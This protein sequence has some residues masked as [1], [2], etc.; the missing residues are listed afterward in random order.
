MTG[1]S[2]TAPGRL[3]PPAGAPRTAMILVALATAGLVVSVQQ[4]LV[5]PLLPRLME[6]F[7]VSVTAVTW[8]FTASL[9]AGAVATPLLSRFGDMYGKKRMI[10]LAIGTLAAGSVVC[11]LSG[12]LGV[13]IAGRAL[14][15]VSVALIP[16]AIGTI[17][18]AFPAHRV[19][20]AIGVISAT[21]GVGGTIGMIV[22]GL[23]ADR[24]T[25]HAPVFLVAAGLALVGMALIAVCA[26]DVGERPGGRP[27]YAGAVLLAAWLICMLLAISQGNAWGWTSPGVLGLFVAAAVLCAVWVVLET[28]IREPLVRLSLLVGS[29]SLSANLASALLGFSMYAMFTLIAGFIQAPRDE[30][31]YGLSGSVLDVGLYTLPST[32]TMLGCSVLA[33]RLA[34]RIGPAFTLAV[35]SVFAG[36]SWMW[37]AFSNAHVY[38]MLAFNAIQGVGFGIAYAALGTLA[39]EHVPMHQSGIA[40]GINALVRTTGGSISGAA[41]A[42]V[43]T[44]YTVAGTDTP[45]LA[46][47]ELC[48]WITAA[49]AALAAVVA[50]VHG[51][52]HRAPAA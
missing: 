35:G 39:V 17:R 22:T 48:F 7:H 20:T 46:A 8:V 11:A 50:V 29:R 9:L 6:T 45:T 47:Y 41:V 13:L 19:T 30:L 33:G 32:V 52:R 12:S 27:D 14:Q 23:I 2:T 49:G 43:L 1:A 31:G 44:A 37:L 4:T 36:L 40:S 42:A 34:G 18:D 28:R 24:T 38:D 3:A 51:V 26:P 21:M 5:I 10:L 25:S 16:L 15:G